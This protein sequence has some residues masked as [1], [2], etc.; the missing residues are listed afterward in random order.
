MVAGTREEG[1]GVKERCSSGVQ[2]PFTTILPRFLREDE[3]SWESIHWPDDT[4]SDAPVG[5][6]A[7]RIRDQN[8][9]LELH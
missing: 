5:S 7:G 2:S 3:R 1:R 6:R 4:E 9:P 8:T